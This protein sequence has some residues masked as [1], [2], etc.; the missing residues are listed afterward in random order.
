MGGEAA[1]QVE[2]DLDASGIAAERTSE[3]P[4]SGF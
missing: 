3:S 1:F 2:R 4:P